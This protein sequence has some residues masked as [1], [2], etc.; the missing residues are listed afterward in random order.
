[1]LH[2]ETPVAR[3]ANRDRR[4][5]EETV[6]A[7]WEEAWDEWRNEDKGRWKREREREGGKAAAPALQAIALYVPSLEMKEVQ[8][9]VECIRYCLHCLCLL[10][11]SRFSF[12]SFYSLALSL[13]LSLA[14][15]PAHSRTRASLGLFTSAATSLSLSLS[16]S[17]FLWLSHSSYVIQ[18]TVLPS[19]A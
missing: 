18:R 13:S 2:C 9:E 8:R 1:M 3:A 17:F 14:P 7:G 6:V 16:L 10:F 5:R 19:V 11:L 4:T 12:F 15:Q